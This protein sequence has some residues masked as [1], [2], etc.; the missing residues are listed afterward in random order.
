MLVPT[1]LHFSIKNQSKSF[2]KSIPRYIVFS[3]DFC[4]GFSSILLRFWRPT[5]SHVGHFF[6]QNVATQ[7]EP[8]AFYVGSIFF[9]GFLDV[10]APSWRP[11][12]SIWEG[13]GINFGRFLVSIFP[14]NCQVFGTLRSAATTIWKSQ[15][16]GPAQ[17]LGSHS[18]GPCN[19]SSVLLRLRKDF[20]LSLIHI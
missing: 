13:S 3:I 20:Y 9:L 11:L 18:M 8:L 1:Y 6:D 7:L 5:W 17:C 15:R 2:K 16:V 10:L 14:D 19:A 12:G 4:I